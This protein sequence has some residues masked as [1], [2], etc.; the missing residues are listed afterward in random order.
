MF[1]QQKD[2]NIST[3]NITVHCPLSTVHYPLPTILVRTIQ[4]IIRLNACLFQDLAESAF[5]H[6][7]IVIGDGGIFTRMV[8]KPDFVAATGLT[9]ECKSV[10]SQH[11]GYFSIFKPR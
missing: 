10:D 11:L 1:S 4:K 7:T 9:I 5:R 3:N 6:I 8:I 2:R